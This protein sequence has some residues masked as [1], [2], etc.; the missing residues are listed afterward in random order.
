MGP[1]YIAALVP[2]ETT[3]GVAQIQ[4]VTAQ[5]S[6]N[7][8]TAFVGTTA[9]GVYVSNG[10]AIAQHADYSLVS[11]DN[12]AH[13]GDTLLVYMTGLGDVSPAVDNGAVGPIPVSTT[14]NGFTATI[15]GVSATVAITEYVPTIAGDYVLALTVPTGVTTGDAILSISGPDSI[16][17]TALLPVASP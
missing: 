15:G 11:A 14:T 2:Y 5:G 7:T 3:S 6:S 1:T 17:S 4:V 13:P 9:P 8:V 16:A 10:Y 12:P